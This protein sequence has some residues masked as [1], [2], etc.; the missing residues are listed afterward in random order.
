MN[1][2]R[3][4]LLAVAGCA[5]DP[6]EL[7][8]RAA[9][10]SAPAITVQ[11]AAAALR[12]PRWIDVTMAP[13]APFAIVRV[14]RLDPAGAG[15][16]TGAFDV[17]YTVKPHIGQPARPDV[18]ARVTCRIHELSLVVEPAPEEFHRTTDETRLTT[19]FQPDPFTAL[20]GDCEISFQHRGASV[21]EACLREGGIFDGGCREDRGPRPEVTGVAM[22]EVE[23]AVQDGTASAS[24]VLTVEA[25]RTGHAARVRCEDGARVAASAAS[26]LPALDGMAPGTSRYVHF[27]AE[28]AA[29]IG[30]ARS[31][32]EVAITAGAGELL[33]R[34][35]VSG[36]RAD[37]GPCAPALGAR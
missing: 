20:P 1:A 19:Y 26:P 36:R 29:R 24:A 14:E 12:P 31:R 21:G 32:C 27:T 22:S 25:A 30:S 13:G 5:G 28:L 16:P 35:C 15:R 37:A 4:A 33:A 17:A 9:P 3:L 2:W 10:A 18:R 34:H 23:L 7:A 11:P 8:G 6:A